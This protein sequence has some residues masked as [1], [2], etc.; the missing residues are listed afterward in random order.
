MLFAMECASEQ[1]SDTHETALGWQ[2]P[3]SWVEFNADLSLKYLEPPVRQDLITDK[4]MR[5]GF[6]SLFRHIATCCRFKNAPVTENIMIVL[7]Q[8]D[9]LPSDTNN[10]LERGDT[11]SSAVQA[12]FDQVQE[13]HRYLWLRRP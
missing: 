4:S 3:A 10:F 2:N 9:E 12:V 5:D 7:L 11:V 8:E 6:C 1:L 13:N